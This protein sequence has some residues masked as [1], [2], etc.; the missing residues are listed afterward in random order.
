MNSIDIVQACVLLPLAW[1]S[2][3]NGANT[4]VCCE[5]ILLAG[6]TLARKNYYPQCLNAV[7]CAGL[8]YSSDGEHSS[9]E[10]YREYPAW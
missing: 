2:E 4:T 8:R 3:R 10:Q 7:A 5:L 9:L 6:T 1:C